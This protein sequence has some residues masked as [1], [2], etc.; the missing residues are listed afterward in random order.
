MLITRKFNFSLILT[1]FILD[2]TT[3]IAEK[4]YSINFTAD[5]T[6]FLSLSYNG[7]T[8]YLFVNGTHIIKFKAKDS[9]NVAA[10]LY[11]GNISEGFSKDNM[12]KT[13][14][15]VSVY[16]FVI[17]Y[18]NIAVSDIP[19]IQKYLIKKMGLYKIFRNIKQIF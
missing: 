13:G 10:P 5:K 11:L 3:L 7:V 17:N 6:T 12:Q 2:G 19:D 4:V 9:E 16:D 15:I 14:L 1:S 8:S 18:D